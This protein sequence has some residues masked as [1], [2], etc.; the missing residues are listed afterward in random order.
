ML[1]TLEHL[2][3][4]WLQVRAGTKAAGVDGISVDLFESMATEQLNNIAYHIHNE[5]YVASPAKGFYVPKKNGGKRL[6]GT[7][8]VRDRIVQRLLLDELYLS[9]EETFLDCS[10]AY[11]PGRGIQKGV[12]HLFGYYQYQ[13]KWIIKTD[14]AD[15]FDNI[16]WALLI[17]ALEELQLEPIVMELLKGQL[18]SGITITG[19]A[20]YPGKGL[21]QG[22]ILSGAL[23]N[24]YLTNFDRKC[25]NNNFNVVRYGDDFVIACSSW[26][27][28][29]PHSGQSYYL[30]AR[31]VPKFTPRKN[32]N[33]YPG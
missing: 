25:L 6:L 1:L 21:L 10:Y 31:T 13:P 12:Q 15:F 7:L 16:C 27:E 2:K 30:V 9:L 33:L 26:S 4:A 17:T 19:K 24:L 20:V 23:A 28:A 3:F 22:G 8:T 18:E 11:R 5:T 32:R 29:K 14:I